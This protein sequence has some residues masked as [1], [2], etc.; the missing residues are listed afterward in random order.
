M[1]VLHAEEEE[2]NESK[3]NGKWPVLAHSDNT[4]ILVAS[5]NGLVPKCHRT[6]ALDHSS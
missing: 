3:E 6:S 2:E 5:P 1:G 4:S